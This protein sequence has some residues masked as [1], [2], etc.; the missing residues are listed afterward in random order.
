MTSMKSKYSGSKIAILIAF[1][2][3]LI[4]GFLADRAWLGLVI[5]VITAA[6][7]WKVL[8]GKVDDLKD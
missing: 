4:G 3:P 8:G 6:A 5:G 2:V 1:F 7:V